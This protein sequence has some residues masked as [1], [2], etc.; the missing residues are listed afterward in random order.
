MAVLHSTLWE[1]LQCMLINMLFHVQLLK[2]IQYPCKHVHV[3]NLISIWKTHLALFRPLTP[4]LCMLRAQCCLGANVTLCPPG[5]LWLYINNIIPR[6]IYALI[7]YK[8]FLTNHERLNRKVQHFT[9]LGKQ[10]DRSAICKISPR[11][12]G[13]ISANIMHIEINALLWRLDEIKW[14]FLV[15][16]PPHTHSSPHTPMLPANWWETGS[17]LLC[18]CVFFLL[19]CPT[20]SF[21]NTHCRSQ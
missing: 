18:L 11:V 16:H 20:R 8:A 1:S 6:I 2:I 12:F 21:T 19:C 9:L 4:S 13:T 14:T 5:L 17:F 15:F 3:T 10:R 7:N